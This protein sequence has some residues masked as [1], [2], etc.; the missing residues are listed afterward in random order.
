MEH[1]KDP[2]FS[3]TLQLDNEGHMTNFFWRDGKSLMD[4]EFF[5]DVI[6]FYT[7]YV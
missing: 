3:Y 1:E 2:M 5:G 4:Y 7:T 6:I